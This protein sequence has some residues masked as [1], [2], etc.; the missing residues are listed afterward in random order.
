MT[1]MDITATGAPATLLVCNNEK[2]FR[3]KTSTQS[4]LLA[5]LLKRDRERGYIGEKGIGFK[6]VFLI[7]S[8][9]YIFSNGY[10]IMFNEDPCPECNDGYIVPQ[11]VEEHPTIAELQQ[12]N[13]SARSLPTTI[14]VLPLKP[15]IHPVKQQ[16][17]SIHPKVLLFL[18][19]IKRLSVREANKDPKLNTLCEVSIS[20]ETE[21][22]SRKNVNAESYTL[23]LSAEEK[24]TSSEEECSY[25]MWR[26]RFPVKLENK[27]ERRMEVEKW[28]I[29]L[30]LPVGQRLHRGMSSPGIYAFLPTEMVTNF[31][32]IVQ[33]D[34]VL[35]SSRETILLDNVCLRLLSVPLFL[36]SNHL[37]QFQY[38]LF[39]I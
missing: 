4:A 15:D 27:V 20:S 18:A 7:T 17:S 35:A 2:D 10:Q 34:F 12:V 26:Q 1:T 38:L 22:V 37:L 23:H 16:L 31:P 14:I 36:S 39:Q 28:I 8:W 24:S 5:V 11:W 6:S 32:F 13:G 21:F 19:K 25:Y 30:A 3:Q 33:A 9:S 29:T